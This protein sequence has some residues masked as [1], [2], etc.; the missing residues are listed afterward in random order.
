MN[1]LLSGLLYL[2]SSLAGLLAFTYPFLG[3]ITQPASESALQRLDAPVL[4]VWLVGVCLAALVLDMQQGVT[5]TRVVALLGVLAAMVAV[6]RFVETAI[7]APGGFSPIFAPV[8]L[9]GYVLGARFGFLLGVMGLL[10][11]A[12][13]TGGLGPWLPYQMLVTGWVG[14]T[15]G[16][17]P[18]AG[19]A[20]RPHAV[21]W[22]AAWGAGWGLLYGFLINL[23]FWPFVVGEP[24]LSWQPGST[25]GDGLTHYLAF[26][27]ISSLVWDIFRSAGN[28]ALILAF[29]WPALRALERCH[30][31][32]Q[33]IRRPLTTQEVG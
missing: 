10:T 23:Y 22:L 14:L 9:A 21:K 32:F 26:Y 25:L 6:L 31:R 2:F 4:S 33:F 15:S 17:L 12:L 5:N 7:P 3:H 24:G 19:G 1:R 30:R 27:V 29:G 13:I 8:I 18:G 16:W 11:S 28:A 20:P